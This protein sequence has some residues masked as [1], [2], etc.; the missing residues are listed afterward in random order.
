MTPKQQLDNWIK[1]QK[2][3]WDF[4]FTETLEEELVPIFEKFE[5]S[6]LEKYPPILVLYVPRKELKPTDAEHMMSKIRD[7]W[8]HQCLIVP[9]EQ[10][11]AI[12]VQIDPEKLEGFKEAWGRHVMSSNTQVWQAV[13]A[14]EEYNAIEQL[15]PRVEIISVIG[16]A[17]HKYEIIKEVEKH[18][19][20]T[21][22]GSAES[23]Q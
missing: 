12:Q 8:P 22:T 7:L 14:P 19:K 1:K 11:G 20:G 6:V 13:S 4:V 10:P 18:V 17:N 16:S 2:E 15:L 3:G 9:V 5:D 21:N 23:G